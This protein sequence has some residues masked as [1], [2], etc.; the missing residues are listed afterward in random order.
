MTNKQEMTVEEKV[1]FLINDLRV[2]TSIEFFLK[3]KDVARIIEE[4]NFREAAMADPDK[5]MRTA[6]LEIA[7]EFIF[8]LKKK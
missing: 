8:N 1:E 3:E 7:N 6:N 2:W 5:Y 4:S